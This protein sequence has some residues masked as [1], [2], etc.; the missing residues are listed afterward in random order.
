RRNLSEIP[1][2]FL[3]GQLRADVVLVQVSPADG[4]GFHSY[5]I[6]VDYLPEAISVARTVIAEVN[7][8]MPVTSGPCRLHSSRIAAFVDSSRAL[9]EFP[10]PPMGEVERALASHAAGI[11]EDGAT[12]QFGVGS[13]PEAVAQALAGHKDLGLHTGLLT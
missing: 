2:M 7:D 9:P 3:D 10:P 13:A 11:V 12:V 1:G 5:G 4:D 6:A 8:A